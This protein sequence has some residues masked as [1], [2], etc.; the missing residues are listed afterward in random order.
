[1]LRAHAIT[2]AVALV[3]CSALGAG[4]ARADGDGCAR[5]ATIAYSTTLHLASDSV[6]CLVNSERV[7]RGLRPLRAS[8]LLHRA[9]QRH[10][11]DMVARSYFSHVSPNGMNVRQR[12][13]RT[14]Y[15]RRR[16]GGTV[17]ET[18]GWGA[19]RQ[20]TPAG[21]VGSF[22]SSAAH[23]PL[24]LDRRFREIGVGLALGAPVAGARGATLTLDF[25]RR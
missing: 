10:S 3:A 7:M 19:N 21:L 17:G 1:M 15:L 14:G 24:L 16:S 18:I 8:R 6:L 9:A 22:M 4:A 5:A 23:R 25:G 11:D 2:G 12:V 20:A 13:R